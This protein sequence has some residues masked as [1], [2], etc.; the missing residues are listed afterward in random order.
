MADYAVPDS[1]LATFFNAVFGWMAAGLG[2]T[3]VVAWMVSRNIDAVRPIFSGPGLIVL[4]IAELALVWVVSA[5]V[6][7]ISAATA[8]ALFLIYAA[9]NGLMFST[10]FLLYSTQSLAGAFLV[11]AG[12]F[13]VM[14]VYGT[15]TKRNL[16]S[17]QGFFMMAL[18]GIIIASI[19]NLFMQSPMM[20]WLITY[21]G[22]LLFCGLTAFDVQR[23]KMI[24]GA[25]AG[26]GAMA[27]RYAVSGALALY[28][29]FINLFL[30]I[31]QILAS[32]T[33][34]R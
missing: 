27:A 17:M 25:T 26:D 30:Y 8:A 6:N 9:L 4:A 13:A 29:D 32:N 34:R 23:L 22:V 31:L 1:V 21:A 11:T 7:K 18:I 5:A 28:L 16:V 10:L 2:V 14:C 3:A 24:A 33:R 12:M 19:V 15:V 20:Y